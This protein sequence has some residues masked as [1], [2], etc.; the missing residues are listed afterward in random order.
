MTRRRALA[1]CWPLAALLAVAASHAQLAERCARQAAQFA[2]EPKPA[3]AAVAAL[4][5]RRDERSL[6]LADYLLAAS[7][8]AQGGVARLRLQ[9]RA[10]SSTDPMLT[11]LALHMPC[12]Q[13]GCRNIEASQWSR[14]EPANLLAWL[15]LPARGAVDG[16]YLLDQIAS[17]VRYARNYQQEAAAL[18]SELS[19]SGLELRQPW[20]ILNPRTLIGRCRGSIDR[21][22]AERCEAVATLLWAD[23]GATERLMALLLVQ[24][25]QA[26]LSERQAAWGP[27][28]HELEA[29]LFKPVMERGASVPAAKPLPALACEVIAVPRAGELAAIS[30]RDRAQMVMQLAGVPFWDWRPRVREALREPMPAPVLR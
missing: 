16:R 15:A 11:V 18:L 22:T 5:Q 23:G 27:R 30:E 17:Q 29:V 2:T 12:V 20:G 7:G 28:L 24:H 6:A 1:R 13:P 14:L 9:D 10:R 4:Q 8:S 21:P 25:V 3:P 26:V 19:P